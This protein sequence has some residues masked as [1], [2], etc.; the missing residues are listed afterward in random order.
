MWGTGKMS[1]SEKF[2]RHIH[3]ERLKRQREREERRKML[4]AQASVPPTEEHAQEFR[5]QQVIQAKLDEEARQ[6]AE[7]HRMA[8]QQ[9]RE[10]REQ[11]RLQTLIR[12]QQAIN[13][14]GQTIAAA[15]AAEEEGRQSG[16]AEAAA[17]PPPNSSVPDSSP[18]GVMSSASSMPGG[19]AS[20]A[21]LMGRHL[22]RPGLV[23]LPHLDL[24]EE[25]AAQMAALK[26]VRAKRRTEE[27]V[28]RAT[29][30]NQS[31][32]SGATGRAAADRA[33]D[34]RPAA[35]RQSSTEMGTPVHPAL[36]SPAHV[37]ALD[38]REAELHAEIRLLEAQV[39]IAI[40]RSPRHSHSH[41]RSHSRSQSHRSEGS[42]TTPRTQSQ[43][44]WGGQPSGQSARSAWSE[45]SERSERSEKSSPRP[46]STGRD[47]HRGGVSS[48]S[49]VQ[50][51]IDERLQSIISE[52]ASRQGVAAGWKRAPSWL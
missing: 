51:T 41:S 52:T 19:V 6:H 44:A 49:H 35:Q 45:R 14:I 27:R 1:E 18:A 9:E 12:L 31:R 3:N 13:R 36:A 26:E 5:R 7:Q 39:E 50:Q 20:S 16:T 33:S 8:E 30:A 47:T 10:Q 23:S 29:A 2:Q 11:A 46:K 42:G 28:A 22:S 24:K 32:L 21:A 17:P 48:P 34:R 43:A 15:A 4:I 25:A 37:R 40:K 38:V